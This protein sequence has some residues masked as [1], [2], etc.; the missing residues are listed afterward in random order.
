[1]SAEDE[2]L[3]ELFRNRA[4]L[5][6]ELGALDVER[7]RLLDR[8]NLPVTA[9]RRARDRDCAIAYPAGPA[10]IV[11]PKLTNFSSTPR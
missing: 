2:R 4:E 6:K 8:L 10:A 11:V 3:V 7:Q 1:M 9:A 5:K